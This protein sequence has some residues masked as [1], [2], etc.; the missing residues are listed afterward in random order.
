MSWTFFRN[1]DTR[2]WILGNSQYL[3]YQRELGISFSVS[4]TRVPSG[5]S[6][7][8][9]GVLVIP[10]V[11]CGDWLLRTEFKC[12]TTD[13]RLATS[14]SLVSAAEPRSASSR[15]KRHKLSSWSQTLVVVAATAAH[16]ASCIHVGPATSPKTTPHRSA[17]C[18]TWL[19]EMESLLML[20][21]QCRM[22]LAS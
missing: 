1:P 15:R 5:L 22:Q 13:L 7:S 20:A 11:L 12:A 14:H 9:R 21:R 18:V 10:Y 19:H 2:Y 6:S 17:T 16:P 3:W 4:S 8:K